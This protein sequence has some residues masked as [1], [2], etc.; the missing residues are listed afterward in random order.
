MD[1]TFSGTSVLE[2]PDLG[3]TRNKF[4]LLLDTGLCDSTVV[5][6]ADLWKV[7]RE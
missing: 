7:S 6:Q 4:V 1:T 5:A 2:F 3:T